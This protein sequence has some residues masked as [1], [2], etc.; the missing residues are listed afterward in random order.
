MRR[1][2]DRLYRASL[3]G[4]AGA[5]VAILLIVLTQ[6][7]FNVL[8]RVLQWS[9]STPVGWLIPSYAEICGY[10]LGTASFL[11]LAGSFRAAAHIRVTL[12]LRRAPPPPLRRRLE[13]ACLSLALA[14][15]VYFLFF[16][17]RLTWQSIRFGDLSTGLLP[18]PLWLPQ[19][20]MTL[21]L[22]VLVLALADELLRLARGREP[23]YLAAEAAA[24]LAASER[25]GD[26]L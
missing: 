11:A 26:E 24:S 12:F 16:F 6:V 22:A 25:A 7:A 20:L 13:L 21:G 15:G 10:L 3:L 2:L 18:I 19:S 1:A 4:A 14:V 8:D 9:G 23:A 17:G 5:L